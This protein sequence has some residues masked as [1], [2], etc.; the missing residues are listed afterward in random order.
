M[1]YQKQWEGRNKPLS[2]LLD[3]YCTV[4]KSA[5]FD[6]TSAPVADP[7]LVRALRMRSCE[8]TRARGKVD[9]PGVGVRA[10]D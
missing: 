8:F 7:T 6:A 1:T 2:R 5:P 3:A 9:G 4:H 10:K